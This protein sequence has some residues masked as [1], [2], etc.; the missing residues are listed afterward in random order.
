MII[1]KTIMVLSL[2]IL[3]GLT[4]CAQKQEK[5]ETTAKTTKKMEWN[6]LTKEEEA[7]REAILASPGYGE[8][9]LLL[10]RKLYCMRSACESLSSGMLG[11]IQTRET[12]RTYTL[13]LLAD[14]G[15]ETIK[16]TRIGAIV[17]HAIGFTASNSALPFADAIGSFFKLIVQLKW[18]RDHHQRDRHPGSRRFLL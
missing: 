9:Y 2:L 16:K 12:L 10:V 1:N 7:E 14:N 13:R 15:L 5:K 8:F 6:K 3:T 17:A 11:S 18:Q 4:A